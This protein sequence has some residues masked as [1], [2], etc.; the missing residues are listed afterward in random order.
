[1]IVTSTDRYFSFKDVCLR[2][3]TMNQPLHQLEDVTSL[4]MYKKLSLKLFEQIEASLN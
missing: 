1:M 4:V 2:K 3:L